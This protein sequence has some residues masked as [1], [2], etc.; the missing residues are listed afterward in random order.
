M[1]SRGV[2]LTV[3]EQARAD[4]RA[5]VSAAMVLRSVGVVDAAVDRPADRLEGNFFNTRAAYRPV[6]F[7]KRSG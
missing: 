2:T 4:H 6:I 1:V 5:E 3:A 7:S